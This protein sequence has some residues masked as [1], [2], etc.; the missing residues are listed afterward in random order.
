M[1]DGINKKCNAIAALEGRIHGLAGVPLSENVSNAHSLMVQLLIIIKGGCVCGWHDCSIG[2][3]LA[4]VAL[5]VISRSFVCA[6]L[7]QCIFT[8]YKFH[9]QL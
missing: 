6:V 2:A 8:V 5:E 1:K 4:A 3:S 7:Q 9:E